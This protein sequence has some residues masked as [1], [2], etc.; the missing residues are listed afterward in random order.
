MI[1]I[2]SSS[3]PITAWLPMTGSR[4]Q[5]VIL[6]LP[7]CK[8]LC[9]IKSIVQNIV[10]TKV[11][12][13]NCVFRWLANSQ[14]SLLRVS[15]PYLPFS[16][17]AWEDCRDLWWT[18]CCFSL[19]EVLLLSFSHN[20]ETQRD[21]YSRYANMVCRH[22]DMHFHIHTKPPFRTRAYT[23]IKGP[24]FSP[25]YRYS[26]GGFC[27]EHIYVC[28]TVC[29]WARGC[30]KPQYTGWTLADTLGWLSHGCVCV[31]ARALWFV[32]VWTNWVTT[33]APATML[34]EAEQ[35]CLW[36]RLFV[37]VVGGRQEM[38]SCSLAVCVR[39]GLIK[40][41]GQARRRIPITY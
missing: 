25:S 4:E 34:R 20:Y 21:A 8:I 2:N 5:Q 10:S 30:V 32:S 14:Q 7:E 37:V 24:L 12:D 40:E 27:C 9:I 17:T 41:R 35:L 6:G 23:D 28:D 39:A 18:L 26:T 13:I 33:A 31:C 36:R 1:I 15:V 11:T 16:F 22:G 3:F 38:R 19:I 29:L